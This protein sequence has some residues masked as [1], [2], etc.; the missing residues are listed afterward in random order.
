MTSTTLP[1]ANSTEHSSATGATDFGDVRAEFQALLS[2]CGLY[3]LSW[4]A[5]IAVTGGD[6]VRW[7]N[8]MVTNNVRDLAP[9]HGVYAFLLNAQG[10]I[11][12][13]IYAFQRGDSL[14]VDTERGQREK[15]LQLFDHYI[16]ADDVEVADISDKLAAVGVSGPKSRSV[17]ERAG[18]AVPDLVDLQFAD[19]AWQ[20]QTVTL[21][22][23][24]EEARE[25]WQVWMAP[26]S[27]GKLWDALLKAGG[28]PT[29]TAAL[30]L[31]RIS[32]GIPQFGGDIRERD[33]PQETGQTRALNFTKGCY[34]GQEIV[35]RIRS[36]GAVHR[37]FTTFAAEGPLPEPGVKILAEEK[38]VGEITSS[39]VLP[40]VGGDQAVALGYLRREAAGKDLRAGT[41]KLKPASLPIA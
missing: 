37:Q 32:R 7:L 25:S 36:R 8:G 27:A 3:D 35:E 17:L 16:I 34:L 24:G 21:L 29:G 39:A 13:D 38:E 14:L 12:A 2:G 5:K 1:R 23:S 40:L 41:A 28:R 30:N 9:G 33:L 10:R 6:R 19:V 15:V 22:R 26:E 11:Q 4:R 31:F 18:L 20:Q